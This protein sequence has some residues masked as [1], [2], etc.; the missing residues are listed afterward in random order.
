MHNPKV[1]INENPRKNVNSISQLTFWWL[2][3][4][5]YKGSKNGLDHED[6][7][8]CLDRDCS[9]MLGNKL[10]MYVLLILMSGS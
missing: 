2:I 10:E 7:T 1:P 8:K 3:P 9:T 5:L 4:T 6:V